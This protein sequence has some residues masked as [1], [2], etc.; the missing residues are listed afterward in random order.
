[1][2]KLRSITAG[3]AEIHPTDHLLYISP[4]RGNVMNMTKLSVL[5]MRIGIMYELRLDPLQFS[6]LL[7]Q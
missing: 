1:M 7:L 2:I 5:T 6:F 3:N 4:S